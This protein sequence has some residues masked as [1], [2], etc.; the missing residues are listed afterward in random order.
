MIGHRVW[1]SSRGRVDRRIACATAFV[2]LAV[3]A[4]ACVRSPEPRREASPSVVAV[5][6][7][8]PTGAPSEP[9]SGTDGTLVPSRTRPDATV[10]LTGSGCELDGE[11]G[12]IDPGVL[13]IEFV[14][15][16]SRDTYIKVVQVP[17]GR[18]VWELRAGIGM[19]GGWGEHNAPGATDVW[20]SPRAVTSGKW[21]VVCFKDQILG[22]HS[23]NIVRAGVVPIEVG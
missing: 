19:A 6:A 13:T 8:S 16:L 4:A 1:L 10:V 17:L 3:F 22:L 11:A 12:V 5:G 2:T 14:N 20:S 23:I 7:A 21:A 18:R 15:E 9:V